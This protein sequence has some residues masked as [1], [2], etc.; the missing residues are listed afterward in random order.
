MLGYA[1]KTVFYLQIGLSISTTI[2]LGNIVAFLYCLS[3]FAL[4]RP[5]EYRSADTDNTGVNNEGQ[6]A[7]LGTSLAHST[8]TDV[9]ID[10]DD[11]TAE[12]ASLLPGTASTPRAS[13]VARACIRKRLLYHVG[14]GL[15]NSN[16]ATIECYLLHMQPHTKKV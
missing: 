13:D 2:L 7:D 15:F 3:Y 10:A 5:S 4:L 11:T 16:R 1:W 14:Y 6:H 12:E 9:G 8:N